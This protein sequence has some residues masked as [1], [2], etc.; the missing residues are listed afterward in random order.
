MDADNKSELEAA[1]AGADDEDDGSGEFPA[2]II[3][4]R[5]LLSIKFCRYWKWGR[6]RCWM[7]ELDE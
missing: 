6:G 2:K 4:I 5:M 3:Q 1:E 7:V